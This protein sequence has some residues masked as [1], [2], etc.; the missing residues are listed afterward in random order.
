MSPEITSYSTYWE[1]NEKKWQYISMSDTG[2]QVYDTLTDPDKI[3]LRDWLKMLMKQVFED[4][5][6]DLPAI[7]N[8][9]SHSIQDDQYI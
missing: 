6:L 5:K 8:M 9:R 7:N 3:L 4:E 2:W 1:H